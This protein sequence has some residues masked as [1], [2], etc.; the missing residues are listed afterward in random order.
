MSASD[1]QHL[2]RLMP[3]ASRKTNQIYTAAQEAFGPA[4][5]SPSEPTSKVAYINDNHQLEDFVDGCKR[6]LRVHKPPSAR[7]VLENVVSASS[8]NLVFYKLDLARFNLGNKVTPAG[9]MDCDFIVLREDHLKEVKIGEL[10]ELYS[11]TPAMRQPR[12]MF[13]PNAEDSSLKQRLCYANP[14]ISVVNVKG[15]GSTEIITVPRDQ[16]RSLSDFTDLYEG[17]CFEAA[18]GVSTRQIKEWL[19]DHGKLPELAMQITRTRARLLSA[20]RHDVEKEIDRLLVSIDGLVGSAS[21]AELE[22]LMYLRIAVL[23]QKLYCSEDPRHLTEA[24][25]L[26]S[27]LGDEFGLATC[28]RFAEFLDVHGAVADHMYRKAET[29]FRKYDAVDLA[30]Y[31]KSNRLASSFTKTLVGDQEYSEL[32]GEILEAAPGLYRR[33]DVLY[34]RAVRHLLAGDITS[35]HDAFVDRELLNG[36]PLIVASMMLGRLICS[37]I[38]EGSVSENGLRKLVDYVVDFVQPTNKWHISNLLLNALVLVRDN[39][40]LTQIALEL[41]RDR[42]L[43]TDATDVRDT[44]DENGRLAALAGLQD[45]APP[46][47]L[48]GPFGEFQAQHGVAIP[49]FFLWS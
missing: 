30:L 49:Y 32:V 7:D 13:V 27:A 16:P 34:N 11:R 21:S 42:I 29:I 17:R 9:L 48:P 24:M 19:P 43:S 39:S 26:A 5:L 46:A 1:V 38:A 8:F 35:A 20:E 28:L 44:L 2:E 22:P 12:I 33:H 37:K 45:Q 23:L 40:K 3:L 15:A 18:A 41:A 6:A 4:G 31:S 25:G 47:P 14:A 10:L 36:R